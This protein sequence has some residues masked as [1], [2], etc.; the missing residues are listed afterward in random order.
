MPRLAILALFALLLLTACPS[1]GKG[2]TNTAGTGSSTAT[3]P[4]APKLIIPAGTLAWQG[5][6]LGSSWEE[7]KPR[8]GSELRVIELW[9]KPGELGMVT[10]VPQGGESLPET[11][12]V[13]T[14]GQLVGYNYSAYMPVEQFGNLKAELTASS[15][16]PTTEPPQWS[17][18]SPYFAGYQPPSKEL[19]VYYWSDEPARAA[20]L[21]MYNS[22]TSLGIVA[23][24]NVDHFNKANEDLAASSAHAAAPADATTSTPGQE[25]GTA[26][27]KVTSDSP[28][29]LLGFT[30]GAA[31]TNVQAGY[32]ADGKL[33]I[34]NMWAVEGKTGT[35]GAT[36]SDL[37]QHYPAVDAWFLDGGLAGYI[38]AEEQTREEFLVATDVFDKDYGP[39]QFDP[40]A[41]LQQT[42]Y[43]AYY[44]APNADTEVLLW[45]DEKSH[46]I[47]IAQY[48]YKVNIAT[49]MLFDTFAYPKAK[50]LTMGSLGYGDKPQGQ[51]PGAS[52]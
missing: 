21:L 27:V 37:S 47:L 28:Y 6:Q 44:E 10:V 11:S 52:K 42:P 25:G 39:A 38:R 41:W 34:S 17:L 29:Q 9:A 23:L 16:A 32:P 24:V 19:Q 2:G 30:L 33:I 15:G 22:L 13:Y 12:L 20:L 49:Y 8:F 26:T 31:Y 4:P 5:W 48:N 40:P 51:Q 14:D 43:Q 3:P 50:D 7:G 46:S 18:S 45:A 36:P 35:F 1:G